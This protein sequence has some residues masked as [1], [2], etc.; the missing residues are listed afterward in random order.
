MAAEQAVTA[1]RKR[2]RLLEGKNTMT[3]PRALRTAIPEGHSG[4][5]LELSA[6]ECKV[7]G[8]GFAGPVVHL[9]LHLQ[10]N[11]M[12]TGKFLLWADLQPSAARALGETLTQIADRAEGHKASG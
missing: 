11:G 9:N 10:E 4:R 8:T 6:V 5:I 1:I 12:L 3:F 7:A 2:R